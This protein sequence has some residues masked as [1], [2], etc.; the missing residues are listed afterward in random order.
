M[1]DFTGKSIVSQCPLCH[2]EYDLYYRTPRVIAKCGHTFCQ[3]CISNSLCVKSNKRV[4]V[5]PGDCGKE[6]VIRKSI[7][8][9]LPKN[10]GIIEIIK[11]MKK[12]TSNDRE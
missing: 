6:A 3:K 9:D 7:S 12:Y 4:F 1:S 2:S 11:N 10:M 5:C 8:D